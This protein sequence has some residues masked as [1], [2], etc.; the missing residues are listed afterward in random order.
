[1]NHIAP[2]SGWATNIFGVFLFI[3]LYGAIFHHFAYFNGFCT[4]SGR[5]SLTFK[6]AADETWS[7]APYIDAKAKVP[8]PYGYMFRRTSTKLEEVGLHNSQEFPSVLRH[9]ADSCPRITHLTLDAKLILKFTMLGPLFA[10][11]IGRVT[12]LTVVADLRL[13]ADLRFARVDEL[14]ERVKHIFKAVQ[15]VP[16]LTHLFFDESTVT[17][18]NQ[19]HENTA[20]KIVSLLPGLIECELPIVIRPNAAKKI[21]GNCKSLR[22]LQIAGVWDDFESACEYVSALSETNV[23]LN[24]RISPHG[25]FIENLLEPVERPKGVEF[26]RRLHDA[27]LRTALEPEDVLQVIHYLTLSECSDEAEDVIRLLVVRSSKLLPPVADVA[28]LMRFLPRSMSVWQEIVQTGHLSLFRLCL[29]V[30]GV[31][32]IS[33]FKLLSWRINRSEFDVAYLDAIRGFDAAS[34]LNVTSVDPESQLSLFSFVRTQES[35]EWLLG[36]MSQEDAYRLM[37]QSPHDLDSH[38][39]AIARILMSFDN[40][41]LLKHFKSH[42]ILSLANDSDSLLEAARLCFI[43]N[44]LDAFNRVVLATHPDISSSA[45]ADILL[46]SIPA[47]QMFSYWISF[48]ETKRMQPDFSTSFQKLIQALEPAP[49]SIPNL[50]IALLKCDSAIVKSFVG[51]TSDSLKNSP[52]PHLAKFLHLHWPTSLGQAATD[53]DNMMREV[54]NR[55]FKPIVRQ[56]A[57][58]GV[59]SSHLVLD[60]TVPCPETIARPKYSLLLRFCLELDFK[61]QPNAA[62]RESAAML[63]AESMLEL[64][65]AFTIGSGDW[66]EAIF[67]KCVDYLTAP[68]LNCCF[69]GHQS[70]M[71]TIF[72]QPWLRPGSAVEFVDDLVRRGGRLQHHFSDRTNPENIGHYEEV[73]LELYYDVLLR[74]QK[75]DKTKTN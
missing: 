62:V 12:H 6:A 18:S 7:L 65:Q 75:E 48:M 23:G 60:L 14:F 28:S 61:S 25:N 17:E 9:L 21:F 36:S 42:D 31:P 57:D 10:R 20:A 74:C 19:V 58:S 3:R 71:D 73:M 33:Q 11:L 63:L 24:L 45:V 54:F 8:H 27:G 56:L 55:V 34:P 35:L 66:Y 13:E 5:Y 29:E 43:G 1:V 69:N 46:M 64:L 39:K 32:Q 68:A 52:L 4:A 72:F 16:K 22:C 53:T 40:M 15:G 2:A 67:M 51:M 59:P 70:I 26:F 47:P 49:R 30:F 44:R 50:L 41:V 37:H 38:K